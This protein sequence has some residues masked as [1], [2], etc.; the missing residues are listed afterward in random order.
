MKDL[1]S[2]Y[3]AIDA[4]SLE[5]G[6]HRKT[7]QLRPEPAQHRPRRGSGTLGGGPVRWWPTAWPTGAT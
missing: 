5:G 7:P 6:W 4:L 1:D 3:A 2:L